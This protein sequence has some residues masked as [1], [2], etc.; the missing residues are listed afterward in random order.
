MEHLIG[1]KRSE[2]YIRR[3]RNNLYQEILTNKGIENRGHTLYTEDVICDSF[4]NVVNDKEKLMEGPLVFKGAA[5]DWPCT[6]KWSKE[7]FRQYFAQFTVSLVGNPGLVDKENES[8][9]KEASM[10]EFIDSIGKD[11]HNY[12]RF[13]RIIDLNPDLKSDV[14]IDWLNR[15]RPK[16]ARGG[17]LYLFMGE[18]G[19]KTDMHC[20]IIQT[21]FFQ[22]KGTKKWTIY[23]PNERIF[24][25]AIADRRPY[26]Y[27][28][29][30]PGKPD[31]PNFPLLKYAKKYEIV[32]EEGDI[33]WFPSFYW[34]YVE[35]LTHSIG[36]TYKF[37]EFKWAFKMSKT[38]TTL[39]F[40]AT[41][42]FL[43]A[44]FYYNTFKN[45]DLLF[46]KT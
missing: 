45:R 3:Y 39:F 14:D 44:S 7:Y 27:T 35:N 41:K 33:L 1:L 17:N 10:G 23:A 18:A 43:V 9:Y 38:L 19:S 15:F 2:K 11:K 37:T 22:V 20:A 30:Q 26:F 4:E 8:K 29:A 6:K 16:L 34:H 42:P 31:D 46:D 36:V 25:D 12:L 28:H 24:I 40:L 21:L 5:K 32:L 13:S